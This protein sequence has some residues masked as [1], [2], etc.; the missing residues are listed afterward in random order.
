VGGVRA[1]GG[2]AAGVGLERVTMRRLA[3]VLAMTAALV[4]GWGDLARASE[5]DS[6]AVISVS[7]R[8]AD[9]WR[10]AAIAPAVWVVMGMGSGVGRRERRERR[11]M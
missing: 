3:G 9:P 4:V 6:E 8:M 7:V 11:A 5:T 1:G 10:P 2:G